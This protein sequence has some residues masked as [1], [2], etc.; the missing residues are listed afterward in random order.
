MAG[1]GVDIKLQD[2][3]NDLG[4]LLVIGTERHESRRIDNQLR[5]RSGRQ[6]DPGASRFYVS[7]EDDLMRIFGGEQVS[8]V[9]NFLKMAEDVPIENSMIS[10]A[11]ESAQ[12]KVEGHNFDIRKTTVEYDD[13][14]NQQR[15]IIYGVRNK[16]LEARLPAP[17]RPPASIGEAFRA[18]SDK[19]RGRGW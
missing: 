9:M 16:V 8:R 13:V 14:M 18:G 2:G 5:G 12:K 1:R 15:Q 4:G 7:L 10:K 3:V 17:E 6:G 19:F 11:I